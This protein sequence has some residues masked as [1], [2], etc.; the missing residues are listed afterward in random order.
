MK[1]RILLSLRI[2]DVSHISIMEMKKWLLETECDSFNANG[3][4]LII[5]LCIEKEIV[6]DGFQVNNNEVRIENNHQ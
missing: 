4:S 2:R 6:D 5:Q 1:N 3:L